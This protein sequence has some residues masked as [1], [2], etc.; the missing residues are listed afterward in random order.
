MQ[1]HSSNQTVRIVKMHIL[2]RYWIRRPT[3]EEDLRRTR[4]GGEDRAYCALTYLLPIL[5]TTTDKHGTGSQSCRLHLSFEGFEWFMYNRTAAYDSIAAALD[6][7]ADHSGS[8]NRSEET[9]EPRRTTTTSSGFECTS[10]PSYIP[11]PTR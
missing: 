6:P 8:R 4:V 3:T 2:W 7:D 5:T 1:Y 10:T 11:F 9:T